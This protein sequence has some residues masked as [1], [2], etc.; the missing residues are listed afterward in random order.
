MKTIFRM[1]VTSMAVF[2][3]AAAP[4]QAQTFPNSNLDTW[5]MR[6]NIEAPA[7]WLVTNDILPAL[8]QLPFPISANNV[9]K[10]ADARTGPFAAQLQTSTATILGQPAGTVPA[11]MLLGTRVAGGDDVPGGL[12]FTARPAQMQFAYKLTGASALTDSAAIGVQLTRTVGG[13][14]DVVAE[15]AIL[16]LTPTSTYT[17]QSLPLQYFSSAQP[18]SV[19]ILIVSGSADRVTLGTTLLINDIS[20]GGIATATRDAALAASISVSPN[21]STDGRYTFHAPEPGL[22]AAPLTVLDATGRVVRRE[23]APRPSATGAGRTL[24][25]SDLSKGLYTVQLLTNRG[26]VTKKVS[27]K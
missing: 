8:L 2:W 14:T 24:D 7:N 11:L 27:I 23:V 16:R 13:N 18:D 15:A 4:V 5:V 25:L 19:R 22:L 21:P 9:T 17:L 10:S 1:L 12:P 3:L 20:F 6:N 26:M